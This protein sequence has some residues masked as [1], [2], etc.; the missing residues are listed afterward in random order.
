LWFYCSSESNAL[1][2]LDKAEKAVEKTEGVV[3]TFREGCSAGSKAGGRYEHIGPSTNEEYCPT[4]KKSLSRS[5]VPKGVES[6]PEVVIN[7]LSIDSVREAM[8]NAILAVDG[9]KGLTG[10]SAGN[11][12]GK[13]GRHRIHLRELV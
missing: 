5:K 9:M 4:L 3:L 6:I 2:V 1:K 13:L 11:Y 7:G 12:G 8:S 10:I